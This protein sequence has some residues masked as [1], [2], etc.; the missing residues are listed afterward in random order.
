MESINQDINETTYTNY[1]RYEHNITKIGWVILVFL[2]FRR[3]VCKKDLVGSAHC[4][5]CNY[6]TRPVT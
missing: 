2:I 3:C 5:E 6:N 4:F 1:M